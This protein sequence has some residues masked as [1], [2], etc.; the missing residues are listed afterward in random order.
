MFNLN[1]SNNARLAW[2][3]QLTLETSRSGTVGGL[4]GHEALRLFL[5]SAKDREPVTQQAMT[6]A[7]AEMDFMMLVFDGS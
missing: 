6:T 3:N 2:V 4:G 7:M 5:L 1:Y